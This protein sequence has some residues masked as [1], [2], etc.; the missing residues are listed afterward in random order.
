MLDRIDKLVFYFTIECANCRNIIKTSHVVIENK[1]GAIFCTLC[2]KDVKIPDYQNLV[3]A[4]KSL[5][6]YVGDSY[7]AKYLN[8][9][10]NDKFEKADST[11]AAH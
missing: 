4:A 11:P 10:L 1:A 7:N 3:T 5:N 9:V 8:L 2:G 6:E